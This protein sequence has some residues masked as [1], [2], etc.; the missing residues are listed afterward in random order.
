MVAMPASVSSRA[1][2]W[3]GLGLFR[4][5]AWLMLGAA[6]GLAAALLSFS[7]AQV[8]A[9]VLPVPSALVTVGCLLPIPLLGL[10]PGARQLEVTA[11]L[12]MLD[13]DAELVSPKELSA[14]HRLRSACWVTL[15]LAM[16]LAGAVLLIG[17]I[18]G[19]V[20]LTASSLGGEPLIGV[21]A[22]VA[23][24]PAAVVAAVSA[25]VVGCLFALV[26]VWL[27][28]RLARRLA[29]TF[30]GPTTTD[31]LL[32]VE[33]RLAAETEHTRLARELHDG[34]GH[35]LTIIAIQ[36]VSA[37][38]GCELGT[39][40][41]SA[42]LEVIA[43]TA[44]GALADLDSMLS[45]L[46]EGPTSITP[47]PDLRDID[48]LMRVHRHSGLDVVAELADPSGLPV[49]TS[50]TGYLIVAEALVNAHRY[51]APGVVHV[52]VHPRLDALHIEVSSPLRSSGQSRGCA[53]GPGRGG[54]GLDGIRERVRFFGGTVT[55]GPQAQSWVVGATL[56]TA[57]NHA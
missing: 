36:A 22:P 54:R 56:P 33:S 42:S 34:I 37:R 47:E 53:P 29:P 4:R 16:G 9:P 45:E 28:G 17:V 55:A 1:R 57:A 8:V 39:A 12:D 21:A 35:A 26:L 24:R 48:E 15:H 23:R 25:G 19:A 43:S 32:L 38:R 46:R 6:I 5:T 10:V 11:A 51:A 41:P 50:R 18:P 3:S 44:Q 27:L 31:L 30:L 40:D 13:A 49:L 52:R 7:L 20:V 14:E 2:T